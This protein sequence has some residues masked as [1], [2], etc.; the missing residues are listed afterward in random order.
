VTTSA[1]ARQNGGGLHQFA[2]FVD[3][4]Q[5]LA[6]ACTLAA[7]SSSY[8]S[9]GG[10]CILPPISGGSHTFS[11]RYKASANDAFFRNRTLSVTVL[12]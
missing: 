10:G 4:A 3:G 12:G 2:L 1:E 9:T 6:N 8:L 11:I 7:S 5:A